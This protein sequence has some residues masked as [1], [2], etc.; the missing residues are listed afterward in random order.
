MTNMYGVNS[1]KLFETFNS[2]SQRTHF[3]S[4]VKINSV[5]HLVYRLIAVY[6]DNH[7]ENAIAEV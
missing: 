2:Y 6:F 5:R 1:V 4:I 3:V 7:T